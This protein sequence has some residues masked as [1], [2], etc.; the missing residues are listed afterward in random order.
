MAVK[1][2]DAVSFAKNKKA[3]ATYDI[4]EKIEAG[5]ILTG[6]EVKAIRTGRINL[7]GGFVDVHGS[8]PWLNSVHIGRYQYDS[9]KELD[10]F[11]KRKLILHKKQILDLE[12]KV[13]TGGITA[14]PLEIYNKK[15]LIKILIGVCRGKKFYDRREELKKKSQQLEIRRS[16]KK[17]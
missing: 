10:P 4:L 17:Y 1:H 13:K 7:K 6:G 15:G 8:T 12:M 16:L 2:H 11:R 9:S 3:F 5:I 14:I